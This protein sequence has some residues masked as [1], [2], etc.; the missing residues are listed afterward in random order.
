MSPIKP[1]ILILTTFLLM[2][3]PLLSFSPTQVHSASICGDT[4]SHLQFSQQMITTVV[5]LDI[6]QMSPE[7]HLSYVAALNKIP[8][9]TDHQPHRVYIYRAPQF[10]TMLVELVNIHGCMMSV[11][12]IAPNRLFQMMGVLPSNEEEANLYGL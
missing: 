2:F 8:P 7:Q 5:N 12:K 9:V 11:D 10:A 3:I 6:V 1:T 4:M